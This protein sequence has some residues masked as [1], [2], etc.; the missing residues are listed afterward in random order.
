MF[1]RSRAAEA[2]R[3]DVQH[4]T[5]TDADQEDCEVSNRCFHE[6]EVIRR[7]KSVLNAVCPNA[8]GL[9][10]SLGCTRVVLQTD[11]ELAIKAWRRIFSRELRMIATFFTRQSP[12]DDRTAN[13]LTGVAVRE[14]SRD[15]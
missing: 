14:R 10:R 3:R 7:Q 11:G 9:I 13:V 4:P 8:V 6:R 5:E 12:D 2:A 1:V 15:R